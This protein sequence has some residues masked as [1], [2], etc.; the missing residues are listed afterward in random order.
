MS[1]AAF[2][3]NDL[4]RR[5]LQTSLSIATLT[6][7]VAS[8]LF[9]LLFS[10]QLTGLTSANNVFTIGISSLFSQFIL[11]IGV[12]I[13]A[14]GVVLAS[15]IGFF[16][17]TQRTRDFGLLKAIGCPNSLVGGYFMT[18]LLTT[19]LAGC[20]FGVILGFFMDYGVANFAFSE[21]KL[22]NFWFVL[23]VFVVFFI[24]SLIFGLIPI[25]KASKM[26]PVTALSPVT[27]HDLIVTEKHQVLSKSG[28]TWKIASRSLLRRQS[29]TFRIVILMSLV[30][31]LLTVC[32]AGGVIAG[33]TTSSWIQ[34]SVGKNTFAIATNSMGNQYEQL[35]STFSGGK[36]PDNFNYSNSN[37]A[38]PSNV[39][40]QLTAL[41]SVSVVDS[42]LVLDGQIQ[43]VANFS[44]GETTG[45]TVYVGGDRT[46]ESLII[47][48]NPS[49][50]SSS[51]NIQGSFL[52][53]NGAGYNA[54]IGDSISLS[55][56]SVDSK[57]N[58]NQANPLLEGLSFDNQVFNIV[59]VCVDPLNNGF[60]TY[61]PINTL[62]N[63]TGIES[64]NLLLVTIKTSAN[65][66]IAETQIKNLIQN[67]DPNLNVFSLNPT[68]QKT[69]IFWVQHGNL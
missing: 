26:S 35:L 54:V 62:E 16:M 7:S 13:F 4:L 41:P 28:L 60:V 50:L 12:L 33:G 6:F 24:L 57:L 65:P 31:I 55:M 40:S 51:W 43:E 42:R 2:P 10:S 53:G 56:Y 59:G 37:L 58:I 15:F 66:S 11:F 46:G 8:T 17:M 49:Q 63:L 18:E 38:I 52:N 47:G 44:F 45:E 27:Y 22:P 68:V 14:V 34:N 5:R 48:L 3:V 1:K 61:L 21:Y 32:V 69:R 67:I 19:T 39:V 23:V 25:L 30:F 9:F 20:G 29:A 64:P 36:A